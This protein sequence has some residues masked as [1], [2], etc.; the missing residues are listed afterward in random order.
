MT[1]YVNLNGKVINEKNATV[2]VNNR[3]FRYGDGCFET[4]KVVNGEARLAEFHFD[5]LFAS[6]KLLQFEWPSFFTPIFLLQSIK[7]LVVKNQHQKLARVRLTIFRG[8]GGL[9]D[10]EHQHPNY[11]IQS[12]V[13]NP[14]NNNLNDNGLVIGTYPIGFKA[15]D[16]L[17]NL[18]SNNFLLYAMAALHSKQHYWNDALILNH[19]GTFADATIANLFIITQKAI[20]TPPLTDGPVEGTMRRHLL[21]HLPALG[22]SV[23]EQSI[24]PKDL[25]QADEC[26]LTNA[27]YGIKWVQQHRDTI[28]QR[29]HILTIHKDLIKS[30]W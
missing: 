20:I 22:Y 5:R 19:K 6:L 3:S 24:A 21:Q 15:A 11:L 7:E 23:L 25:Q 2:S 26:F 1:Q 27:I 10:P 12:W 16:A 8:E 30:I 29:R 4:I 9:Y 17:A 14:E 18:K 13:L 28:F